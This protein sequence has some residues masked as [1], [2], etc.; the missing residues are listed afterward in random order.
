MHRYLMRLLFCTLFLLISVVHTYGQHEAPVI[1]GRLTGFAEKWEPRLYISR[2]KSINEIYQANADLR[3]AAVPL[4]S[5]GNFHFSSSILG[6]TTSF[7]R[8]YLLPKNANISE[9]IRLSPCNFMLLLLNDT[10]SVQITVPNANLTLRYTVK[11]TVPANAAIARFLN[12][13]FNGTVSN[14]QLVLPNKSD[15]EMKAY[16][17]TYDPILSV[18]AYRQF[19]LYDKGFSSTESDFWKKRYAR[20]AEAYP[21]LSY[22]DEMRQLVS[23]KNPTASSNS[24]WVIL[25]TISLFVLLLLLATYIIRKK[26]NSQEAD[27]SDQVK[28]ESLTLR[29][30]AI[31]QRIGEG[32]GNQEIADE[33]HIEITTVKT[34][35]RSIYR[36]LKINSRKEAIRFLKWL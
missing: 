16:I 29:E 15:R 4:D 25:S 17:A 35:I 32:R 36:K 2:L 11:S 6:K 12:R 31:L 9:C 3:I 13:F 33:L 23:G 21:D 20:L 1:S 18:V 22:T 30:R 27:I 19:Y 7:Y 34:H 5:N 28:I 10:C 24:T 14:N 8:L 26:R